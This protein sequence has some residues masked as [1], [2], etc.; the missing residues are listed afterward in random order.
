MVNPPSRSRALP[1]GLPRHWRWRHGDCAREHEP[2]QVMRA[3]RAISLAVAALIG[4]M[5]FARDA[6]H[7]AT[8]GTLER[9]AREVA[10][11][12]AESP[13]WP[14]DL[15]ATSF[16]AQVKPAQLRAIGQQYFAQCGAVVEVQP[17]SAQG[18][19]SGTFDLITSKGMVVSMT[20]ALSDK[21][22]H[23]VVGLLFGLPAPMLKSLD[24]AVDAL[25]ALGGQVSFGVWQLGDGPPKAIAS[26]DPDRSMA[27]GSAFKL[28]VLGALVGQVKGGQRALTD[29]VP[30]RPQFKSLP[31][32]QMQEW[33]DGTPVTIATAANL[34]ISVSDNTATDLLIA[35]IGRERVE[36]AMS[37]MGVADPARTQPFLTTAEMFLLK[38]VGDG[39]RAREYAAL[40]VGGRR[41]YLERS[42]L[43]GPV[44]TDALNANALAQ[45]TMIDSIE[46]F[47][48]A[49]DLARTMDWI[50]VQTE[51]D[52]ASPLMQLREALAINR[53][54][55]ISPKQFPWVGFKGGSEPGAINLTYLLK[56]SRGEWF[57]LAATWNDP[58]RTLDEGAFAAL[59]QRA[60]YV[61]GSTR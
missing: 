23:E 12:I 13:V 41:A 7:A 38:F 6:A 57:A 2:A 58:S 31:S 30:L 54:L 60:I 1:C 17:T 52:A 50:R 22:P 10:E 4:A 42:A 46:W 24:E 18:E 15:L 43:S 39:S 26:L 9:R 35:T 28:H 19:H 36:A 3:A 25:R 16:T 51:G 47:A 56:S 49:S 61:L 59:I 20:L 45:P 27:I 44:G 11:V 5:A 37:T 29:I 40:D 53:G 14:D 21:A 33:P 8:A 34:M 48:S 32:G 55:A